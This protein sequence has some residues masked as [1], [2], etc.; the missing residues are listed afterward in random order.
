MF[1]RGIEDFNVKNSK[2][3]RRRNILWILMLLYVS[4]DLFN[5]VKRT[6][7][8]KDVCTDY[9][10]ETIRTKATAVIWQ[11]L[12]RLQDLLEGFIYEELK[13]KGIKPNI[14]TCFKFLQL[15]SNYINKTH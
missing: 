1:S 6:C 13:L 9:S 2:Q 14:I 15:K 11:C 3:T 4:L 10:V 7:A 12:T 8:W 5:H